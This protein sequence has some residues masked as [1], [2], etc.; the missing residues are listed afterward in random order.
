MQLHKHRGHERHK[1]ASVCLRACVA[2]ILWSRNTLAMVFVTQKL[3][4]IFVDEDIFSNA[5]G[6]RQAELRIIKVQRAD[7]VFVDPNIMN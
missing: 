5:D 1:M 3:N 7:S 2:D 6:K 4:H